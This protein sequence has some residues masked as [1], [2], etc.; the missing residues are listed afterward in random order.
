MKMRGTHKTKHMCIKQRNS[1]GEVLGKCDVLV[2][3]KLIQ[4][5][6]TNGSGDK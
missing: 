3:Y 2:T 5:C 6:L 1:A 4:F